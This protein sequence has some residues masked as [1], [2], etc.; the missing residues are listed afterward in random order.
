MLHLFKNLFICQAEVILG[1]APCEEFNGKLPDKLA[2]KEWYYYL[3][4]M[5]EEAMKSTNV[6]LLMMV[7]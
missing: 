1:D 6:Q 4:K 2:N 5:N 3:F 7:Y